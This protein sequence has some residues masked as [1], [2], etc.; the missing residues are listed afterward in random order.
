MSPFN[1]AFAIISLTVLVLEFYYLFY[2]IQNVF[3]VL[4][5]QCLQSIYGEAVSGST[6]NHVN[7]YIKEC[8]GDR[9]LKILSKSKRYLFKMIFLQGIPFIAVWFAAT[10]LLAYPDFGGVEILTK[11]QFYGLLIFHP[12]MYFG[13]YVWHFL[14]LGKYSIMGTQEKL[15][16]EAK[17]YLNH[18]QSP[19]KQ[20]NGK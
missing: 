9:S 5:K 1:V 2:F 4:N 8:I 18:K 16:E 10:Y 11:K 7:E 15:L 13:S 14:R 12:I 17:E 6:N 3:V 20:R 19:K